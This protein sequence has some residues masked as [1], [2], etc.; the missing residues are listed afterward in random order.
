MRAVVQRVAGAR[1]LA[2]GDTVG[3]IGPG[4]L[5]FLGV[6]PTDTDSTARGLAERLAHLRVFAGERDRMDRSVLDVH[7]GA[8]VV[9]QFTLFADCRRGHRPSFTGA[10]PRD[11]A[12]RLCTAVARALSDL[13]VAPVATGRFGARMVVDASGD[14]PV[15]VV[16]SM[17]DP[18]W[19]TA[20]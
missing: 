17:G 20:C 19:D 3:A 1:V 14:G 9:S 18:G 15:T 2:G 12:D 7:G 16:V 10:A 6:G 5:A 11:L 4:L 8:L 13:G